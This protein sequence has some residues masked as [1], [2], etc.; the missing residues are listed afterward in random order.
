MRHIYNC[1]QISIPRAISSNDLHNGSS[2]HI[3]IS[4][5]SSHSSF[6]DTMGN[7]PFKGQFDFSIR[8]RFVRCCS[9]A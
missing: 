2:Q 3:V 8:A 9:F 5:D 6:D 7:I 4:A 1:E